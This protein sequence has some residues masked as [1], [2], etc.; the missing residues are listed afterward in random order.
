MATFTV[1]TSADTGAGSLRDAITAANA[2]AG[3][4]TVSFDS[5]VFD[6]GAE[7]LVRLTSGAIAITD[8]LTIVAGD[9]GVTIT[10]DAAGDDV[11]L[12]G[13][14]TDMEATFDADREFDN[15]RIFDATAA[16]S[17]DGL[18]L[19]GGWTEDGGGA[20]TSTA[21]VTLV[22]GAISG[23][24]S[25]YLGGG[26][27]TT[28]TAT[29]V[30]SALDGN[31]LRGD[32]GGI[33]VSAGAIVM[34]GSKATGN[35]ALND[36]ASFQ[37]L[38]ARGDVT[39]EDSAVSDTSEGAGIMGGGAV[40]IIRSVVSGN[41]ADE[42]TCGG[43]SGDDV[44][45]IDST[46]SDNSGLLGVGGIRATSSAVIENST[47]AGNSAIDGPVGGI[48]G[49]AVVVRDS[50]ITGNV[51]TRDDGVGGIAADTVSLSNSIVLGNAVLT[52]AATGLV[53]TAS[54]ISGS[55]TRAG[56]NIVGDDVFDGDVRV[57]S[58]TA[59]EVFAATTEA[60][61]GVEG[62][63]LG[64]NG[65][66]TPTVA[67]LAGGAAIGRADAETAAATDQRGFARDRRPD[68]GAFEDGAGDGIVLVGTEGAD[69]L[70]GGAEGDQLS[71]LGG[72]DTLR[73]ARRPDALDGGDGD[74]TLTGGRGA[75]ALAGGAGDD[76]LRG[77]R[78]DD[79]IDGGEGRDRMEG[80]D[81]SDRFVFAA[82]FG[83]DRITD[84]GAG[85][86]DLIDLRALGV[87]AASFAARVTIQASSDDARVL[88]QGGGS[89]LLDGVDLAGGE[90]L[91]ASD[92][93]LA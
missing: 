81:G 85:G 87:T 62:G 88:V 61:P 77:R 12:A 23:N 89:I 60:A 28:G 83:S 49:G 42:T 35:V 76:V 52:Y 54:D 1:T 18:T 51:A 93:L 20:V 34:R 64:E 53:G 73:G 4:D 65:G 3:A 9:K 6:G 37:T 91:D 90:T 31:V 41:R 56:G 25:G 14:V 33:A 30:D 50:T 13:G 70:V 86:G 72:D 43:I 82:G 47:I 63:A 92:F 17:L 57:G 67:L 66:P 36:M 24:G 75:D 27:L 59:A 10:G 68:L 40:T 69:D 26:V 78:G 71:G 39:L 74:D 7:D 44:R 46:V 15:S 8:A 19:T 80:G 48:L 38:Y 58:A 16:L 32:G 29:L 2:S 45:V 5:A 21:D 79:R 55:I 84:F 11:T 22:G